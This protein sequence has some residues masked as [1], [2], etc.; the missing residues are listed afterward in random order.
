[1]AD[2]GSASPCCLGS[3]TPYSRMAIVVEARMVIVRWRMVLGTSY[4]THIL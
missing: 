3:H 4:D 2:R 1:M